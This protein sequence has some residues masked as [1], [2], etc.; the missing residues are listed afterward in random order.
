MAKYDYS[1]RR[2]IT[3]QREEQLKQRMKKVKVSGDD[4][5]LAQE[6]GQPLYSRQEQI[7]QI[8]RQF[9]NDKEKKPSEWFMQKGI[10]RLWQLMKSCFTAG[11]I[12]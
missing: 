5:K 6:I 9:Y 11:R 7:G 12:W 8:T 2:E 10:L 1:T 3:I 4:I